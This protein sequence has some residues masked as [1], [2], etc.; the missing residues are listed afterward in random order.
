MADSGP[1]AVL[2]PGRHDQIHAR[3]EDTGGAGNQVCAVVPR[4]FVCLSLCVC[5]YVCVCGLC[6]RIWGLC[7]CVHVWLCGCMCVHACVRLCVFVC[8]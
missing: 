3:Q 4:V 7:L 8:V 1:A 2:R 5:V 6:M